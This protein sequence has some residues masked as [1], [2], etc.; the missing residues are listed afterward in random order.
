MNNFKNILVVSRSSKDCPKVFETGITLAKQFNAH[1]TLMHVI[2]D[3]F[4]ME[5]WNLPVPYL[6]EEY[7]RLVEKIRKELE[8]KVRVGKEEGVDITEV[9]EE[10]KPDEV[11]ID[12][13]KKEKVDLIVMLAHEEG[14]LE[15]FLFGKTNDRLVRKIPTS[16]LLC[17]C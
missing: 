14:R 7:Q 3:P 4:Y 1:L 15:H 10:G 17:K 2:H 5:G 6:E 11:I 13:V 8:K 9:V 12:F 16:I